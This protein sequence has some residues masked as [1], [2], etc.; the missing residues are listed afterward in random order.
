M[1]LKII[2]ILTFGSVFC[3]EHDYTPLI[4]KKGVPCYDEF[5]RPQVSI[6]LKIKIKVQFKA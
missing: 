3:I 4:G 5:R 2:V 6:Y 1:F